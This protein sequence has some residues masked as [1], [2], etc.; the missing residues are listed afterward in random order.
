[1]KDI[2]EESLL[3]WYEFNT[4]KHPRKKLTNYT[5]L[6]KDTL[7]KTGFDLE[8]IFQGELNKDLELR[9]GMKKKLKK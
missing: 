4:E 6:F 1:M 8:R 9:Y 2:L 5:K 3:E 7:E